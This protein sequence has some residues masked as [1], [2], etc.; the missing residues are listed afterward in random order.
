MKKTETINPIIID[1]ANDLLKTNSTVIDRHEISIISIVEITGGYKCRLS[2]GSGKFVYP[3]SSMFDYSTKLESIINAINHII[4][5]GIINGI[6]FYVKKSSID[7]STNKK[8]TKPK[9][10]KVDEAV[11]DEVVDNEV[12]EVVETENDSSLSDKSPTEIIKYLIIS[13]LSS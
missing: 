5:M 9:Q 10:V 11:E 13:R 12:D 8:D 1:A 4:T 7:K 2:V 6:E 3:S